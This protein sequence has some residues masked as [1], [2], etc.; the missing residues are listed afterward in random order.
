MSSVQWLKLNRVKLHEIPEEIGKLGKLVSTNNLFELN[1]C[2]Y[3]LIFF[4]SFYTGK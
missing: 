3:S 4:V 1:I 2:T